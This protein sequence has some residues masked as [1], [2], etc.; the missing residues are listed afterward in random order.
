MKRQRPSAERFDE[1]DDALELLHFAFRTSVAE[2]DK[3]LAAHGLGRV[4]HRILYFVRRNPGL[5]V[6]DLLAILDVTKQSLHRPMAELVEAGLVTAERSPE[7]RRTKVLALTRRGA[8]LED[9]LSG[10]QRAGFE[11]ALATVS[12]AGERAWRTVMWEVGG[13]RAKRKGERGAK[14]Q[15]AGASSRGVRLRSKSR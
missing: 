3:I 9:R 1:L 5:S 15:A 8:R 12:S 4:H 11:A 14:A 2:P 10:L 13:R 7:S 6:G